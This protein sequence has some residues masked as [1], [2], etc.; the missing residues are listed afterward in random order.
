MIDGG[1]VRG[2]IRKKPHKCCFVNGTSDYILNSGADFRRMTSASVIRSGWLQT[3]TRPTR[4]NW[5]TH[6]YLLSTRLVAAACHATIACRWRRTYWPS[7][8]PFSLCISASSSQKGTCQFISEAECQQTHQI[9]HYLCFCGY[10]MK[11]RM[12]NI[13]F[14]YHPYS[15]QRGRTH[16]PVTFWLTGC[17]Q[18][19]PFSARTHKQ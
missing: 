2:E 16:A 3:S 17:L 11:W 19:P 13:K 14:V 12:K 6:W 4:R 8:S 1:W 7:L 15:I 18:H 5:A 9:R 10:F